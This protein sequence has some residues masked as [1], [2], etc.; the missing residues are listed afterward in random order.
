M[1]PTIFFVLAIVLAIMQSR[2]SSRQ[3][4]AISSASSPTA[5]PNRSA[6][7]HRADG[8]DSAPRPGTAAVPP[9]T[10]VTGSTAHA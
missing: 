8:S 2:L 5:G 9:R 4:R 6:V 10:N 7:L 1:P 3:R